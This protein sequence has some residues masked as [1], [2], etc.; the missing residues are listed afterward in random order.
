VERCSS[1]SLSTDGGSER[2]DEAGEDAIV[3]VLTAT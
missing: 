3:S 2:S 1:A